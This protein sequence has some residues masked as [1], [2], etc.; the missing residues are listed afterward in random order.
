MELI[1][2]L[3]LANPKLIKD[4]LNKLSQDYETFRTEIEETANAA[5]NTAVTANDTA[6]TALTT[7]ADYEAVV[8]ESA[9]DSS[10]ARSVAEEA[11]AM[12]T[13]A[14]ERSQEAALLA[15]QAFT[16]ASEAVQ[17]SELAMNVAN[18]AKSTIDQALDVGSLGSFV[19]NVNGIAL[20][21][22]H[23][24][25]DPN[26][27]DD[28]ELSYLATP[29]LVREAIKGKADLT[30]DQQE[31]TAK[32]IS[33]SSSGLHVGNGQIEYK[34]ISGLNFIGVEGFMVNKS[35]R[36]PEMLLVDSV[37][38]AGHEVSAD[39]ISGDTLSG[40]NMQLHA[41]ADIVPPTISAEKSLTIDTPTTIFSGDVKV[42]DEN[43]LT[44]S[45]LLEL[46]YPIGSLYMTLNYVNPES[47]L[48]GRW[49]PLPEGFA[50]WTASSGAG[51]TIAAGL[52]NI[53]GTTG[54][55][56]SS[57][58]LIA[59]DAGGFSGAMYLTDIASRKVSDGSSG[60]YNGGRIGFNANLSN[61]IYGNSTTVQPPAYKV[62]VWKR[63]A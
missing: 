29:T 17:T 63:T 26:Q 48:G 25:D 11:L 40:Y 52:P 62:Y 19:H 59:Q 55:A 20:A 39:L 8:M 6:N 30:N 57:G 54:N 23:M 46:V 16:E 14:D 56:T 27:V 18:E 60:K 45:S 44:K 7:V 5:L 2:L 53:T 9:Q 13:Q 50:L 51:D 58:S 10:N 21:H 1:K 61:S 36:V 42:N 34:D 32:K 28:E 41:Y 33:L 4:T 47:F 49:V 43:V 37:I 35:L 15:E 38:V 24:T 31:I 22:A 3:D 12:I